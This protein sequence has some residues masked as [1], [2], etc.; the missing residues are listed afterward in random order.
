MTAQI[1]TNIGSSRRWEILAFTSVGALMAPLSGSIIAVALPIMGR[2]LHLSFEGT[3]WVQASYLL[4]MAVLMIPLGRIAD[5]RGRMKFYLYGTALFTIGSII[6]AISRGSA[7]IIMARVVQ[8]FGGALLSSTSSALVTAAF[9][10]RE[11]G[12]AMGINVMA[13]YGGLSLGPPLGGFLVDAF[14]W[15]WVFLMNVPAGIAILLWGKWLRG[16]VEE[17]GAREAGEGHKLDLPG[18]VLLGIGMLALLMPLT[19]H[20]R[21][22]LASA[23]TLSLFAVSVI[24]FLAFLAREKKAPEPLLDIRLLRQNR[25]F[26]YGNLAALL[27]YMGIFAVGMLTS[28]WLQLAQGFSAASAGWIMLG[29]PLVQALLSP[30]AGRLSDHY[31]TKIFT[32]SGMFLTALGMALLGCLS[33]ESGF[34]AIIASLAVVGVGMASF[35][36]PNT[37]SV[38]GSVR[39]DSLSLAGAVLGTTRVMGMTMSVAIL[40]G[41]A[42]SHL[43]RGGWQDLLKFGPSGPGADAFMWG[44]RTAMLAGAGFVLLGFFACLVR[45]RKNET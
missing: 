5:Q 2:E 30:V 16:A 20:A 8:G 29:Q 11:R 12:K 43:G 45:N 1:N 42:A 33:R 9:P 41:L 38:M 40:G 6:A 3:I 26:A 13:V 37:S 28:V 32:T 19:L 24:S 23:P 34:A 36:A 17:D 22:G 4:T 31:G 18:C 35:S 27:N 44:Y 21:W 10:A 14:S 7:G 39:R 25:L 15:H